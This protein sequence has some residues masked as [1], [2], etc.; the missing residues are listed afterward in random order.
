MSIFRYGKYLYTLLQLTRLL[1]GS[2]LISYECD[3]GLLTR[4]FHLLP[5]S[6]LPQSLAAK[7]KK[8]TTNVGLFGRE[9]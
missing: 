2:L 3:S 8:K 9:E 7:R 5:Y 6:V 1:V 4:L